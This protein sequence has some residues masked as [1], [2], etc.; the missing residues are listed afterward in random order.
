M[1]GEGKVIQASLRGGEGSVIYS[2][3]YFSSEGSVY[4]IIRGERSVIQTSL[5]GG[6]CN[7]LLF[8]KFIFVRRFFKTS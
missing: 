5:R 1:R 4:F 7:L 8:F 2:K 6:E 3:F